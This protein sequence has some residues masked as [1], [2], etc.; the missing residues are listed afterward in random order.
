MFADIRELFIWSKLSIAVVLTFTSDSRL[1]L[2]ELE[3]CRHVTMHRQ[4]H[5]KLLHTENLIGRHKLFQLFYPKFIWKLLHW[6]L[7][8]SKL[9]VHPLSHLLQRIS[10]LY[11]DADIIYMMSHIA[12]HLRD[13]KAILC[14]PEGLVVCCVCFH[15]PLWCTS[16]HPEGDRPSTHVPSPPALCLSPPSAQ[17]HTLWT[18]DAAARTVA[19][20]WSFHWGAEGDRIPP[21]S[22]FCTHPPPR[23][24]YAVNCVCICVLACTH[25]HLWVHRMCMNANACIFTLNQVFPAQVLL[26]TGNRSLGTIV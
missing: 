1:L 3:A 21:R 14:W 24:T 18:H 20:H 7:H 16:S 2:C 8:S 22:G 23:L 13:V 11:R 25:A 26:S 15:S 6:L 12:L 9:P 5:S 10:H 19:P 17:C 4:I